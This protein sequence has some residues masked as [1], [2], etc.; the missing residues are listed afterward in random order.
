MLRTTMKVILP[1]LALAGGA[2]GAREIVQ[3]A[4]PPKPRPKVERVPL[5]R[6]MTAS[7]ASV[8]L[9]VETYG[10]VRPRT[11]LQIVPQVSG[12]V[13]HVS[14]SLC[15]GGFFAANE[16]L[17]RI[18]RVDYELAKQQAEALVTQAEAR[19][20]R[21]EAEAEVALREWREYGTGDPPPLVAREPQLKEARAQVASAKAKLSAALLDLSRTEIRAPYAGRVRAVSVEEGQFIAAGM[22]IASVFAT[23]YVEVRLAIPDDQLAFLD[24]PLGGGDVAN[25]DRSRREV[26]ATLFTTYAGREFSWPATIV[27]SE[28]EVDPRT[29]VIHVLARVDQPFE[30]RAPGQPPLMVGMYLRARIPGRVAEDVFVLPRSALYGRDQVVVVDPEDRLRRRTVRNLRREGERVLV[31]EGLED[32]ERIC[33]TRVEPLVEGMRVRIEAE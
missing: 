26:P 32:G 19:L 23:D 27:R 22:P 24:L 21:E 20:E 10:T 18:D 11:E 28:A 12:Q 7:R 29:R 4:P 14:A 30:P 2:Y 16:V 8:Q 1:L 25:G 31:T 6:V 13:E 33:L 9:E 3:N 5:V 17:V 15:E